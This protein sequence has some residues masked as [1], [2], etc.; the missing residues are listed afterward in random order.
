MAPC[1]IKLPILMKTSRQS[2]STRGLLNSAGRWAE[3]AVVTGTGLWINSVSVGPGWDYLSAGIAFLGAMRLWHLA[4]KRRAPEGKS[5]TA[6][7]IART[8]SLH[9]QYI[10]AGLG[11]RA[12]TG[13]QHD[14][15]RVFISYTRA[16]THEEALRL[17]EHLETA[18]PGAGK[19]FTV[20]MDD[21]SIPGGVAFW[22]RISEEIPRADALIAL[23]GPEWRQRFRGS[24]TTESDAVDYVRRE[25]EIASANNVKVIVVLVRGALVNDFDLPESLRLLMSSPSTSMLRWEGDD[26]LSRV[27]EIVSGHFSGD[28]LEEEIKEN[29]GGASASVWAASHS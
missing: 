6:E 22:S 18:F 15:P 16:D 3:A 4:I 7:E 19:H 5:P 24:V 10:S 11:R 23:V 8:T 21:H 29:S 14:N 27:A 26:A 20:F 12:R 28:R 1:Y 25:I 2:R 13:W 17:R 9:D